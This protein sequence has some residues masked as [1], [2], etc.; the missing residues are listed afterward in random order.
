MAGNIYPFASEILLHRLEDFP[1]EETILI[2]PKKIWLTFLQF[3]KKVQAY[4]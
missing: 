1:T 4:R 3:L 2:S